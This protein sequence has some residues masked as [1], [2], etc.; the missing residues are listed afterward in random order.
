MQGVCSICG[1]KT[2]TKRVDK[3]QECYR[4]QLWIK[5]STRDRRVISRVV[6][7]G[8]TAASTAREFNLSREMIRLILSD[9][10]IN[11]A[12]IVESRKEKRDKTRSENLLKKN[13]KECKWCG[14]EFVVNTDGARVKYCSDECFKARY[15]FVQRER[16]KAYYKTTEGREALLKYRQSNKNSPPKYH[17][18]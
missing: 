11:Y 3:C 16:L 1:R 14:E 5:R 15:R 10:G 13:T 17:I 9:H 7:E 8:A 12:H 6:S 4:K 2:S 18:A